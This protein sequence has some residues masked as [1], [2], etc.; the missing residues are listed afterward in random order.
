[1]LSH[2]EIQLITDFSKILS[3]ICQA[4]LLERETLRSLF[5]TLKITN[6]QLLLDQFNLSCNC[7]S[8]SQFASES[9]F[10][11]GFPCI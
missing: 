8:E 1:M 6:L 4:K 2:A 10:V 9:R 5:K 11:L 7:L 3:A